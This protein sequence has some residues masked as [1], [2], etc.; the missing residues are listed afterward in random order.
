MIRFKVTHAWY[1]EM[2][3]YVIQCK[4]YRELDHLSKILIKFTCRRIYI[5]EEKRLS[6]SMNFYRTVFITS[7]RYLSRM[8]K[9]FEMGRTGIVCIRNSTHIIII[10]TTFIF[11]Q[12]QVLLNWHQ[13]QHSKCTCK[14][15]QLR[16]LLI[17]CL[18]YVTLTW[19][20]QFLIICL[21]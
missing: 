3:V 4:Y 13:K 5:K 9:V 7:T 17:Q 2:L 19:M 11:W 1:P 18:D 16:L 14:H 8:L 6:C 12:Q 21:R 15:F 20:T 10:Q